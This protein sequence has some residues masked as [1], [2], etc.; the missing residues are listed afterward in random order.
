[1]PAPG[2]F[3]RLARLETALSLNSVAAVVALAL[4]AG[5][6]GARSSTPANPDEAWNPINDPSRLAPDDV[7]VLADLPLTGETTQKP[8]PDTYWPSFRGGLADRWASWDRADGF[9]Y[10]LMTE[11][12]VRALSE[13]QLAQL[14]PAEKFDI[15]T[16]RFDFPLVQS[17]RQRT[18]PTAATWVGLCHGW[19]T[20]ALNFPEPRDVTVTGPSGIAVPFGSSDI[21]ALLSYVQQKA[22]YAAP[23]RMLG[24][25]CDTDLSMN[26]MAALDPACRDTNAGAFHIVVT[27]R[28]GLRDQP[29]VAD[30]T[31]DNQVWNH[32]VYG[33]KTKILGDSLEVLASAAPGTVKMVRVQTE[34]RYIDE[35]GPQWSPEPWSRVA[36]QLRSRIFHYLLELDAGG[37]IIGG[38]WRDEARPDF[39][40]TQPAP[41]LTGDFA[42][43][44]DIV[45]AATH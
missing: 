19:A 7:D 8:W 30:M 21:K 29:F 44:A 36:P 14:S 23:L 4:L 9:T 32:P 38:E 25:R 22:P 31:R 5:G 18:S 40:W 37:H 2:S 1:M 10:D 39:L 15:Y 27:N 13:S 11:G 20:A 16:G 24:A 26:P 12:E 17:E 33:F 6:C 35:Y 34:L 3:A 42:P 43:L 45:A 41:A 28:L